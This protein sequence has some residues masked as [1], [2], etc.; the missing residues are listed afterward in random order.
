[1]FNRWT[2]SGE[3]TCSSAL[4]K[5]DLDNTLSVDYLQENVKE[6]DHS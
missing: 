5:I 6:R 3:V 4:E 1:M 2:T